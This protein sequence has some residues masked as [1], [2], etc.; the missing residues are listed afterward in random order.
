MPSESSEIINSTGTNLEEVT[1]IIGIGAS[2]GGL[3]AL[4]ELFIHMPVNT[5]FAFVVIQH[6]SPDYKSMMV[7]LLSRKTK[8]TV[9]R[10]EEGMSIR[11]NCIY[12]IPPRNNI[13]IFNSKLYLTEL[14]KKRD[15]NLPIDFFF[16]SLAVDK[17]S[18]AV[19]IILSGTGS[20]G[21]L[22]IK[23]IKE[24]G[25]MVM[26]Q[27]P[28]DSKFDG[29]PKSAINT[30]LVDYVLPAP[31]IP[32]R[33]VKYVSH[34]YI[35]KQD[36]DITVI[37][38]QNL[39][40]IL[41]RVKMVTGVDFTY[42]KPNTIIRR[43]ERRISINQL[44]NI[45]DYQ[46]FLYTS[47]EE[48]ITLHRELL[49]GVTQF[50]RDPDAFAK[51]ESILKD[52]V[53][54]K[55]SANGLRVWVA[56]C[57]TGEE[58]YSLAILFREYIENNNLDREIKI[59]ATDLDK[60]AIEIAS[61][62][63]YPDSIASDVSEERLKKYFYKTQHGFQ[64]NDQTRRL[65]VFASHNLLKDP[66]FS[67]I[68]LVTCRNLLIYFKPVM[69][70]KVLGMFNYALR[71]EGV[72]FLG[73]SESLNDFSSA[74]DVI[75]SKWKIFRSLGIEKKNISELLMQTPYQKEKQKPADKLYYQK[76]LPERNI[77]EHTFI[78]IL[79]S[80]LSPSLLL[81]DN[82]VI[83]HMFG[84]LQPF[85]QH[86]KGKMSRNLIDY[87]KE[88]LMPVVIGLL[89]KVR[90]EKVQVSI[91]T[92]YYD[93]SLLLV[94]DLFQS[95]H[96]SAATVLLAFEKLGE[97]RLDE[98]S[99]KIN[100]HHIDIHE[101]ISDR[102]SFLERELK[103]R[104]ENLQSTI[105]ELE[106]SNEELQ[107]TN[108]EL[109][110]SNEEL[111]STNEELQSVNEELYTVN[112]E[113][114][115]KI[116]ELTQVNSDI[117]NLLHNIDVGTIFL[118]SDLKIRKYTESATQIF[119]ILEID[120]GRP[121]AHI[122]LNAH[123]PEINDD[124]KRVSRS[125]KSIDKKIMD[126]EGNW[127][128]V[129][130]LPYREQDYSS[131]GTII[132]MTEISELIRNQSALETS[133]FRY[134]TLLSNLPGVDVYYFDLQMNY[135]VARGSEMSKMVFD[136]DYLEGK[137]ITKTIDEDTLK[138][139]LPAYTSALKGKPATLEFHY[140]HEWFKLKTIP[141]KGEKDRIT[142]GIALIQNITEGKLK[143]DQISFENKI[144]RNILDLS[145][146][147]YLRM[148]VEGKVMF[149]NKIL[150]DT[151]GEADRDA[152]LQVEDILDFT[153]FD[154]DFNKVYLLDEI[155]SFDNVPLKIRNGDI[156]M[157]SVK[158]T[159]F[160]H[161]FQMPKEILFTI[162]FKTNEVK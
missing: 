37:E 44:D 115:E 42:Y 6:L 84:D 82:N 16:R 8:M 87:I 65:V 4:E 161:D 2:A 27:D 59:F 145:V 71:E 34:P 160:E 132:T 129:K 154:Y 89:H 103:K 51:L 43:I 61:Q 31:Q 92:R 96:D 104:D 85:I 29:M 124:V 10:V 64:V 14:D 90:K 24:V 162:T 106:T 110:A 63:Y 127:F 144:L 56:G 137:N 117:N 49:I 19:G 33:L 109:V 13:N 7:E 100:V 26:V 148:S 50:F 78:E 135:L 149:I 75:D 40:K 11:A 23:A 48:S 131:N 128:L 81:D 133:E 155:L 158:L 95:S 20:D 74:F 45:S 91:E 151:I 136:Y 138:V 98:N 157:V 32:D 150:L 126:L 153:G 30:Q 52:I 68:D 57:S 12:L 93:K 123:Y 18:L 60:N 141:V 97:V 41:N 159:P 143:E 79:S 147:G 69:Q 3:E 53:D 54:H 112:S 114:Q 25:G 47:E 55:S 119:N 122:S 73:S 146:R 36:T 94:A 58:A 70:K 76:N 101:Q 67:K 102:V 88:P 134:D 156:Q 86:P 72:L 1:H 66:P 152:N 46:K 120:V 99:P 28:E 38:D 17:S 139:I 125:L 140:Q 121:L 83:T 111:Q 113:Y 22:G 15:I 142:G 39:Q 80:K 9:M 116:H 35:Q 105:E 130:I 77:Y 21:T 108:E 107:A 62:A 5:G 118:D